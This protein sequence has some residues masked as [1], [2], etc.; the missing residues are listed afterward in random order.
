MSSSAVPARGRRRRG[1]R[2]PGPRRAPQPRDRV[3]GRTSCAAARPSA[4]PMPRSPGRAAADQRQHGARWSLQREPRA[5]HAGTA[6]SPAAAASAVGDDV[7]VT[8][9]TSTRVV[10]R[11]SFRH[12]GRHRSGGAAGIGVPALRSP[13]RLAAVPA[14]PGRSGRSEAWPGSWRASRAPDRMVFFLLLLDWLRVLGPDAWALLSPLVC[15]VLGGHGGRAPGS[16][17][18][19]GAG[20][21]PC[22]CGGGDGGAAR[23]DPVGGS[24]RGRPAFGE[25]EHRRRRTGRPGWPVLYPRGGLLRHGASSSARGFPAGR[26]T[27][28]G[29]LLVAVIAALVV[30]GPPARG[31]GRRTGRADRADRDRPGQ[32]PRL[33]LDFNDERRAAPATTTCAGPRPLALRSPRHAG[34][35]WPARPRENSD[36][37]LLL[38]RADAGRQDRCRRRS[39]RRTDPRGGCSSSTRGIQP[40]DDVSGERAK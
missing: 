8:A 35:R 15:V 25:A 9:A 36:I 26:S 27:V 11:R 10:A 22:R 33:G 5:V 24:P 30:G 20:P 7:P 21:E 17:L 28:V 13:R 38:K 19:A 12:P 40:R 1:D 18:H 32:R 29:L 37:L 39:D 14:S 23:A 3:R 4:V 16:L 34:Q 2:D 6:A 31:A